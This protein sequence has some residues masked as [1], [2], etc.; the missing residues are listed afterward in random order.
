MYFSSPE[1]L[2]K[3][4]PICDG[5]WNKD[6]LYEY[7]VWSC[8]ARFKEY[9][10]R[11]F[12]DYLND[13][14]LADILFSFLLDDYYDGSDSQMGAARLISKLDRQLLLAKKELLLKAQ[15]NEVYWKRPFPPGA[16]N[17]NWLS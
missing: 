11:F 16:E 1:E 8:N 10:N 14:N 7:L 13:E 6:Y 5:V 4:V 3:I 17:L 12:G 9:T 2:K 15:E